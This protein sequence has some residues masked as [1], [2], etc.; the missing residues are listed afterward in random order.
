MKLKLGALL[1][2]SQAASAIDARAIDKNN[3]MHHLC[4]DNL[5]KPVPQM[6]GQPIVP[7]RT[8]TQ[9]DSQAVYYDHAVFCLKKEYY[10]QAVRTKDIKK[11][12][13]PC[14]NHGEAGGLTYLTGERC[15][16]ENGIAL[17]RICEKAKDDKKNKKDAWNAVM[18]TLET[19]NNSRRL[20]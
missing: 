1:V 17:A 18:P 11:G 15:V 13:A 7:P 12:S 5:F 4:D 16:E 10:D 8:F 9:D 2:F 20:R 6:V 14:I 3:Y 19:C